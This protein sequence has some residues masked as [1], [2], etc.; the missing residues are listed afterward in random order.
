MASTQVNPT[1]MELTRQKKKLATATRGHKLLKDKRD[2]LMRQFL[3]LVIEN[4]TLREKVEEGLEAVN[5]NFVLA[6]ASSSD[7]AL[8]TALLAPKQEVYLNADTRNV[9]SVEI[10]VFTTSTRS[11][12]EGDI[13]SYGF[14][15]TSGDLDDAVKSLQELLPDMLRLAEVEKS[16]QLMAA[17]I[18]KTRRR[19]NALEYVMI[20]DAQEK[21]RYITMK[22]D[23]NERSTQIRL[24][25]VK[26]MMLEEA[27]QERLKEDYGT[28]G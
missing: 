15:F 28:A 23:E 21:I 18:E 8:N 19:V 2:E 17:E 4:K 9:M 3:E 11:A 16:C 20:P 26:D 7:Q 10:P 14:A 12:D 1:R 6:R 13:Y 24:M 22:L 27:R 5:K 25:K